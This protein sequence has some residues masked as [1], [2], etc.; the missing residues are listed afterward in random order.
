MAGSTKVA[1]PVRIAIDSNIDLTNAQASNTFNIEGLD[2]AN[3]DRILLVNQTNPAENG[4]YV[5]TG[6][7]GSVT[8]WGLV[9]APDLE[10]YNKLSPGTLITVLDGITY[11]G[12]TFFYNTHGLDYTT[13][14][15]GAKKFTIG[16]RLDAEASLQAIDT[17]NS[18]RFDAPLGDTPTAKVPL[19]ATM[20]FLRS[21]TIN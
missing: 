15:T 19:P 12:V 14:L 17:L 18:I 5:L 10:D 7:I 8:T 13:W 3:G 20:Y 1:I 16:N 6:L 9:R 11:V 21:L 4:V 2:L